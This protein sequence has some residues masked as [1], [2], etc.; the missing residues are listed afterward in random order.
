MSNILEKIVAVKR[1]AVAALPHE[2]LTALRADGSRQ[3]SLYACRR[4]TSAAETMP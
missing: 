4:L 2:S 3:R 1:G